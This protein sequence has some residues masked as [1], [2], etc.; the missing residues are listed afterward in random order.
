ME[1]AAAALKDEGTYI[2][3][4]GLGKETSFDELSK[5]ANSRGSVYVLKDYA[6]IGTYVDTLAR[7]ICDGKEYFD[8]YSNFLNSIIISFC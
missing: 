5:I 1:P 7:G 6:E 3:A 4:V 8:I 2:I